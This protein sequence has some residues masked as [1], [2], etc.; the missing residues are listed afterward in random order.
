NYV[1]G[2]VGMNE[3]GGSIGTSFATGKVTTT[4]GAFVGGLVGW[5]DTNATI[6]GS[7]YNN[8]TDTISGTSDCYGGLVGYNQGSVSQSW[9]NAAVSGHSD[10]GGLI[11]FDR[12]GTIQKSY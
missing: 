7:F 6:S 3:T 10:L 2:L 9:S 5:N 4:D 1:G 8:T 11:G 12:G